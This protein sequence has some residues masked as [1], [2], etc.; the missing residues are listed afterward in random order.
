MAIMKLQPNETTLVEKYR[1]LR[2]VLD[3]STN[4]IDGHR[5]LPIEEYL[6]MFGELNTDYLALRDGRAADVG[7]I[8]QEQLEQFVSK[9][10]S[11]LC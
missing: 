9:W 2:H 8:T 7:D 6:Q 10:E 1:E 4:A 5:P 3:C 11:N